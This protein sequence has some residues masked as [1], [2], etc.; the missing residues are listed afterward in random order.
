MSYISNVHQIRVLPEMDDLRPTRIVS[1]PWNLFM[2]FVHP[3]DCNHICRAYYSGMDEGDPQP[4]PYTE[5]ADSSLL[6]GSV[7]L[8]VAL[9]SKAPQLT[10]LAERATLEIF[11]L[12]PTGRCGGSSH[13]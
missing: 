11:G 9:L 5:F 12:L 3:S 1:N 10:A 7:R 4:L 13:S 6:P 2:Q 8:A